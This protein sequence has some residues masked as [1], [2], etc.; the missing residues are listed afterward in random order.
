M[1]TRF[2]PRLLALSLMLTLVFSSAILFRASAA[3]RIDWTETNSQENALVQGCGLYNITTSYIVDIAHHL[4]TDNTGDEVTEQLNVDFAGSVGNAA[5]GKSYQ[6]D[7]HFT[8]WSNYAVGRVMITDLELRFEVGTP[9]QFAITVDRVEMDL[10]PDP[11]E[12][13]KQFV[14]NALQM[15]L[16]YL[17][18]GSYDWNVAPAIPPSAT[19]TETA[20]SLAVS[21]LERTYSEPPETIPGYGPGCDVISQHGKPC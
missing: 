8:R 21:D 9:G 7:G 20:L 16:C 14:P 4:I 1:P 15:E 19:D 3:E 13:I 5:S 18:P 17:L 2:I 6:Y 12:V 11:T 10:L